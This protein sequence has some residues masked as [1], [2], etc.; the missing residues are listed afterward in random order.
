MVKF[1]L[2]CCG[3][4]MAAVV[5][6]SQPLTLDLQETNLADAV[7]I[8]ARFLNLN[9]FI[10]PAVHGSATLHVKD[11]DPE[12]VFDLLL[13]ANGL[14]QT[15][16]GN[17]RYIASRDELIRRKQEEKKWH[18]AEDETS[19]VKSAIIP[20]RYA[21][22]KDIAHL[23]QDEKASF[24]SR[25]AYVRVDTR[26]NTLCIQELPGRMAAIRRLIARLDI[27]V[28]QISIS[29]R[30][31]SVD[32]DFEEEL[33]LSFV[34]KG[35]SGSGEIL[36]SVQSLR[37]PTSYYTLTVAKLADASLLEVKLAA[38]ENAGHA[39]IISSPSLFTADQQ[40]ASIESGEEV[41]YQEV[42]E[43]GGTAV[44]FKKA[45][46]GLTVTPQVLPGN[47]VLLQLQINQDRPGSRVIQGMPSISTRQIVTSVLAKDGQ[48]IV[49]GGVYET[50]E[51]N[52]QQR[53]P[54]VS[55]IPV[56]GWLFQ[57]RYMRENKRELLI[58]V[59]PKIVIQAKE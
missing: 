57:Q 26:T 19:P 44:T 50:N 17:L 16:M 11:A 47:N 6:A 52:G 10:S 56:L 53:L 35:P 22:A 20:M 29:A 41:P 59:T 12:Q 15:R 5:Y 37:Q 46:L 28:R 43:S 32:H 7:R 9:V 48:T 23:L 18:E 4:L 36:N 42:S 55:R 25:R 1:L 39:E 24:M 33:G 51:E 54:F 3:W 30:L 2:F 45:V 58:F 8:V 49:L 34:E 31:V 40:Q 14:A 13:D 38:L 21:R 27:P